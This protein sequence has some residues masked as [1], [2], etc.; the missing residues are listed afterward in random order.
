MVIIVDSRSAKEATLVERIRRLA[1]SGHGNET[2]PSSRFHRDEDEMHAN[3]KL[4]EDR[5]SAKCRS[6]NLDPGNPSDTNGIFE[7]ISEQVSVF[8]DFIGRP[9]DAESTEIV[10]RS[11]C[12]LGPI[13]SP[14]RDPS[15]WEIIINGPDQ[16]FTKSHGRPPERL[17]NHFYDEDHLSRTVARL[18]E[19]S[20]GSHRKLD[21]IAGLQDAQLPDGS[22][23]HIVHPDLTKSAQ[24]AVNIRKFTGLP[25]RSLEQLVLRDMLTAS[26]A[27]LLKATV[28]SGATIL[29]AGPPGSGKTTLLGCLA[30]EIDPSSRVVIAEEV[31]ETQIDLENVAHLQTRPERQDR[32]AIELR[33]LVAGFL[34]MAPDLAV[35]GEVRDRESLPF[36]LTTSSGVPGMTTIHA[37]SARQALQRMGVIAQLNSSTLSQGAMTSLISEAVDLVV[38]VRR[39]QGIPRIVEVI[40]VEDPQSKE[41]G[42]YTTTPILGRSLDGN[43]CRATG[44]TPIRLRSLLSEHGYDV[45]LLLQMCGEHETQFGNAHVAG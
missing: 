36:L 16:I 38:F 19:R 22:R 24:L 11:V 7:V 29:F 2:D 45:S 12:G 13:E 35:V 26:A 14:M 34:R 39:I 10:F 28:R 1:P 18:L 17:R 44:S 32:P 41:F 42:S 3:L 40:A 30:R 43:L 25:N 9:M 21:P 23:V 31:P 8:S 27:E 37:S 33:R 15:V 5:V 6:A 20:V 4:L